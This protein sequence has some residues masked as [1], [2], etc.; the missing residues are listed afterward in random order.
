MVPG[1]PHAEP[2]RPRDRGDRESTQHNDHETAQRPRDPRRPGRPRDRGDRS[3]T[4]TAA[5][6]RVASAIT[7]HA[8]LDWKLALCQTCGS[9]MPIEIKPFFIFEIKPL[10]GGQGHTA[11]P[12]GQSESFS[13]STG[14][15][16]A[17]L[18]HSP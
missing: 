17:L 5:T 13:G 10:V 1:R 3:A 9:S 2:R 6:S 18:S 16:S 11:T 14:P 12:R 4:T 7:V 15:Q 8:G